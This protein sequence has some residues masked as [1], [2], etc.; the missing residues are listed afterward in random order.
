M[1]LW[2]ILLPG[3]GGG[4][5]DAGLKR[6][7]AALKEL[8]RFD[9]AGRPRRVELARRLGLLALLQVPSPWLQC[10]ALGAAVAL[11]VGATGGVTAPFGALRC[12][13][14]LQSWVPVFALPLVG[15]SLE[16][17]ALRLDSHH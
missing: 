17:G 16:A 15:F 2:P 11:G 12:H 5:S 6:A 1:A 3:G 4:V 8:W 10:S 7:S 14:G 9:V 13:W